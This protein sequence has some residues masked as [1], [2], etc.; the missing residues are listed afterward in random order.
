MKILY[1][2]G[3]RISI[4][5]L[6]RLLKEDVEISLV[7]PRYSDDGSITDPSI[8]NASLLAYAKSKG[9]DVFTPKKINSAQTEAIFK[10]TGADTLISIQYDKILKDNILSTAKNCFNLHFAPLPRYRGC[11]PIPW[12]IIDGN[13]AGVTLHL[14]DTGIDTGRII[15]Q[16]TVPVNEKDT[17]RTVYDKAVES[18][19]ELFASS[20]PSLINGSFKAAPQNDSEAIYHPAGNPYDRWIDWQADAAAIDRFVR[21]LTFPPYGSAR[22]RIKDSEVEVMHPV[23]VIKDST[24]DMPGK[25]LEVNDNGLLVSAKSGAL[26]IKTFRVRTMELTAEELAAALVIKPG[27]TFDTKA[28]WE[29]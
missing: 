18:G 19:Y 9:L 24:G 15:S 3:N 21:A 16:V 26:L 22:T 12:A 5:C 25:I 10:S 6:E 7:V 20:L 17:A 8:W 1:L 23:T 14:M 27:D 11:F 2:G 28:S 4:L 29:K 13:D